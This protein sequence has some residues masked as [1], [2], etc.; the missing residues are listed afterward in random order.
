[1]SYRNERAF[2]SRASSRHGH[3][4]LRFLRRLF[5]RLPLE[6][7]EWRDAFRTLKDTD[8]LIMPGTGMLGDF[9]IRPLDLHYQIL[10]WSIV[11]RMRRCKVLFVSVGAGP[12]DHP[13]S[14][15]M[16]KSALSLAHYRSY[17]DPFSKQYLDRLGFDTSRDAVYPD[18]AYSLASPGFP[19]SRDAGRTSR[20]V[21]VGLMDYYG[22]SWSSAS[23]EAVY[24]D[25]IRKLARFVAWL[26][27]RGYTVRLLIGDLSYDKRAKH[28]LSRILEERG[29]VLAPG[30][31]IDEPV[32]SL[33]QLWAQ[34]AQTDM[35]LATRFHNILLALMLDKPVMAL[36]YH[37]KIRSLM[38]AVGLEDY[39]QEI[40][41]LD[42]QRLM[43]QFLGLETDAALVKASTKR[44]TQEC[45]AALEEQ[46]ERIFSGL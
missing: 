20:V 35:V 32:T 21:G 17:R 15:W 3:P 41:D 7:F 13:L 4:V 42:V 23:G 45:R 29:L 31:I 24:Q 40:E 46:Y 34:L 33:E 2:A 36:S 8:M 11:A 26:L 6:L 44:K 5:V 10:K 28:D 27:E 37:Q 1:M 19:P 43:Q 16:V 22:K 38:A 9:G 14:R 18:L 30:Q 25:Y 39:C 12:I